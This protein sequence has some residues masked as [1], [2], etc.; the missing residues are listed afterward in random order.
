MLINNISVANENLWKMADVA[1]N[2]NDSETGNRHL[3][4]LIESDPGNIDQTIRCLEK[5]YERGDRNNTRSRWMRYVSTRMAGLERLGHISANSPVYREI[6]SQGL[7]Q[8][9]ADRNL[10][11]AAER[12]DDMTERNPYDLY[13]RST[14]AR[15]HN[16]LG[17]P[18]TRDHFEELKKNK[19]MNHPDPWIRERWVRL[20]EI[21]ESDF[22]KLPQ[23]ILKPLEGSPMPDLS[24]DDPDGRWQQVI[25]QPASRV[26]RQVDRLIGI[27]LLPEA[28]VPWRDMTGILDASRALDLHLRSFPDKELTSLRK[29]QERSFSRENLEPDFT[30][31]RALD[32]FRRYPWST[33][34]HKTLL[35]TANRSLIAGHALAA[36][37]SFEDLINHADNPKIIEF[38]RTGKWIALSMIGDRESL[39]KE[40]KDSDPD[41]EMV[42]MDETLKAIDLGNKLLSSMPEKKAD[43]EPVPLN[44]LESKVIQIPAVS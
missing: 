1:Y 2:N 4:E 24:P 34:A 10:F 17:L 13:W 14:R 31:Q 38:V 9:L 6:I 20:K 15:A 44:K 16:S 42:W 36:L 27:S 29:I 39:E 19:D 43:A 8:Y 30:N 28:I 12:H 22:R 33:S 26:S 5:I 11:V 41:Q 21:L 18:G 3:K 25:E 37:R 40:I 23:P 32:L 35:K 7:S